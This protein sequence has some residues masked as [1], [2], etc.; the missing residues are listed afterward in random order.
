MTTENKKEL[1]EISNTISELQDKIDAIRQATPKQDKAIELV[2]QDL[3]EAIGDI[4][5]LTE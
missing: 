3:Q 1:Q 4:E 5:S 2:Y